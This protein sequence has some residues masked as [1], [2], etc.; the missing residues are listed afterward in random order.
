MCLSIRL[1]VI[2]LY[3]LVHVKPTID[4]NPSPQTG[5]K[6][7]VVNHYVCQDNQQKSQNRYAINQVTQIESELQAVQSINVFATF[8]SK[9]RATSLTG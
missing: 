9:A 4:N 7:P 5:L 2:T 8:H 3:L 1:L 6:V